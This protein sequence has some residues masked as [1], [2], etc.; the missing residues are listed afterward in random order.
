MVLGMMAGAALAA[1]VNRPPLAP[2]SA[3][4]RRTTAAIAL[5]GRLDEAD[6]RA[7]PVLDRFFEYFP[8]DR[9]VPTERTEVR[10]LYDDR[11]LYVGFRALLRDPAKLRKP[12]VRRHKVNSS[13][14]YIQVYLD[15]QGSGRTAYLFRVNARGV[16]TDGLQDEAK[17]T[18]STDPDFDWDVKSA[19]DAKGWSAELRIPLSTLR[20]SRRGA[21][22]WKVVVTRG[23]PRDQ[24]TQMATAPFPHD[25]SCFLCLASP[26]VFA[27]LT[28]GAE[29]LIVEPSIVATRRHDSGSYGHGAHFRAQPSLDAKWLPYDGAAADLTVNPDFSQ[30]EADSPQLTANE[31]FAISLPEKRPFFRE[32]S[33]L[34]ETAIPA[35]YTRTVTAPDY[36]LRFTHRSATVNGT[37]FVAKDGGRGAIVEP[38]LLSSAVGLPDFGST[39]GFAHIT[40][41]FGKT[42]VGALGAAKINDDGSYNVLGGLDGAWQRA[43]DRLTG[44]ILISR[45]RN[46]DRPDLLD[47]WRGQHL[48]GIAGLAEWSHTAD[49]VWTLRYGRYDRGFRSW[50]GYI[51][52]TGYQDYY[53]FLQKPVYL[54]SPLVNTLSPYL[55]F[56]RLEALGVAEHEQDY[57]VGVNFGGFRGLTIDA[58]L[59]PA[60]TELTEQGEER[61]GYRVEWTVSMTPGPHIP[62][63]IV[64]GAIGR[65]VDYVAGDVVP[66]TSL[67]ATLRTRPIDRFELEGRYSFVHLGDAPGGGQRLAETVRELLATWYFGPAFYVLA[68]AQFHRSKRSYPIAATDRSSLISLQ[69]S[70]EPSA[71]WHSYFGI[72]SGKTRPDDPAANGRSTEIYLK[73][74]KR[75]AVG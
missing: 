42:L 1:T 41:G 73:I 54:S 38:G 8:G 58:S 43:S 17:Q 28:P 2:Q 52:R 25:A 24:N 19:I 15:P 26:L 59:H 10:F 66:A 12:F 69:F 27:A 51:P 32:G 68:D 55:S 67:A 18:E 11:Y 50:L 75:F 16:K 72:R 47:G 49:L 44:Q 64:N 70:W 62:G 56:D 20:V 14:D 71:D 65:D 6:W 33:D 40:D 31:R 21:Q 23:V 45:T 22:T 3:E 61:R 39:V 30:V 48:S 63:V 37:A 5:D 4:A 46:P 74:L 53:G 29:R 34:I 9:S 13:H 7:A 36:G 60:V 35:L 57:A